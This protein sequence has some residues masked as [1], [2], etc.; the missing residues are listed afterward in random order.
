M[1]KAYEGRYNERISVVKLELS[2]E[3]KKS[4]QLKKE[5]NEK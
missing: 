2:E 4:D 3:E 1:R 5:L